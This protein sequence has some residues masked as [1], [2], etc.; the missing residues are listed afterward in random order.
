MYDSFEHRIKE[1]LSNPPK[2]KYSDKPLAIAKFKLENNKKLRVLWVFAI[3]ISALFFVSGFLL[4]NFIY[5]N[6]KH[7]SISHSTSKA[8]NNITKKDFILKNDTV[9][10]EKIIYIH[11]TFYEKNFYDKVNNENNNDFVYGNLVHFSSLVPFPHYFNSHFSNI[12]NKFNFNYYRY[13]Q[14]SFLSTNFFPNNNTSS[15]IYSNKNIMDNSGSKTHDKWNNIAKLSLKTYFLTYNRHF[16][17]SF[18]LY[19]QWLN[20]LAK[21]ELMKRKSLDFKLKKFFT[22]FEPA[23]FE[24]ES[25]GG[26]LLS[27]V[28]SKPEM[29]IY[30]GLNGKVLFH[31][32][33]K[34]TIGVRWISYHGEFKSAN[35]GEYDFPPKPN[36]KDIYDGIYFDQNYFLVPIGLEYH[37]RHNRIF[38]P[39]IGMGWAL[40]YYVSNLIKYEFH[41]I[42]TFEEFKITQSLKKP[43]DYTNYWFK[44]GVNY[45]F[46][47]K[48]GSSLEASY[49]FSTK[50]YNYNFLNLNAFS[51][52]L[53]AYYRF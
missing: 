18:F 14:P 43:M 33:T 42:N 11:D 25:M 8:L 2:F 37:I 27:M 5:E 36:N 41:D 48:F 12:N 32:G 45:S 9:Y 49:F 15:N 10:K 29:S 13:I 46:N 38:N 20:N 40:K 23:G 34:F 7:K 22:G 47:R 4:N 28:F 24:I 1:K 16:D 30:T 21:E 52:S 51:L 26:G 17:T 44:T 6:N 39:Y 50:K 3:I 35:I 31:N 19:L 53:N